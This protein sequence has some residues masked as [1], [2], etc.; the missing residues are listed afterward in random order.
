M[1]RQ[2]GARLLY[3]QEF[4]KA[5]RD[6][7]KRGTPLRCSIAEFLEGKASRIN[8]LIRKIGVFDGMA[9]YLKYEMARLGYGLTGLEAEEYLQ[10]V[11]EE[12]K[13]MTMTAQVK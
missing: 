1:S 5:E 13:E 8:G 4:E 10:I 3:R 11:K 7:R 12:A 9:K 2:L 6:L